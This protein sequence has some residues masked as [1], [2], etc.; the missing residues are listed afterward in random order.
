MSDK[1]KLQ[2]GEPPAGLARRQSGMRGVWMLA[3]LQIATLI[4]VG[5]LLS[6]ATPG[7][8]DRTTGSQTLE[9]LRATAIS[10]EDRSLAREAAATWREYL[11]LAPSS[12]E[13]SKVLYRVGG[14][15]MDAEDFSGAVTALVEA[16]QLVSDDD[17]LKS[18]LGPK[19][20]EC[21]RRL[22]R[23]GEVGREL[24]RQ[25]EVGSGDTAQGNVLA[26]FAGESFTDADLDQTIE[27]TIDRVLAMQPAGAFPLSREQLLKQYESGE[28]RQ[29]VLQEVLQRELFSR[30]ARE[31]AIDRENSFQQTR[32]FLEAELLASQFLSRELAKIQ[33]T[34]VDVESFYA[35]Q[36]SKY[37][38]PESAS[39]I[40]LPLQSDQSVDEV[41]A[42]VASPDD[43]RKLADAANGDADVVPVRIIK[44]Q[45]HPRLGETAVFFDLAEGEW[46]KAPVEAGD[47]RLLVL[48]ESKAPATTPPLDQIRFRVES[49]YRQRKQ[50][51][52]MQ[53]LS[54]DL[55]SRY[56]VK[57]VAT[58]S[59]ANREGSA[60]EKATEADK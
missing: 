42:G 35:A 25:V 19:I 10:L 56:D 9:Q 7:S 36:K 45:P 22:G 55:M 50:Q 41:L 12:D 16:E 8:G 51:E 57:I 44:G 60:S 30:R 14:L 1:P 38:Q 11:R 28:A 52:L 47:E 58:P 34:D 3:V 31:L 39:V 48:L 26:T 6:G 54:A 33:P 27:R 18:K 40:V 24:S 5:L 4:V 17:E 20:V 32:E 29:G 59:A 37:H 13:R 43:F 23:Y 21:L 53:K 15:L 46:T 49:D 2:L